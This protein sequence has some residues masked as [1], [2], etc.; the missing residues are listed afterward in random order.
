MM[1]LSWIVAL[2]LSVLMAVMGCAA[3]TLP[4]APMPHLDTMPVR[5]TE[6]EITVGA[7]PYVQP[8]R[9]LDAFDTRLTRK[10][11]LPIQLFIKNHR[12]QNL[13]V[14]P[15]AIKLELPDGSQ[16]DVSTTMSMVSQLSGSEPEKYKPVVGPTLM[17]EGLRAGDPMGGAGLLLLS[18]PITMLEFAVTG[19]QGLQRKAW[20]ARLA[21]YENVSL[22]EATLEKGEATYGFVFFA[23]SPELQH[24]PEKAMLHLAFEVEDETKLSFDLPLNGLGFEW[25]PTTEAPSMPQDDTD[26]VD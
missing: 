17:V 8:A 7:D 6:R 20:Q 1:R 24:F 10:G 21:T 3:R 14:R 4:P 9:Q 25:E 13:A 5:H 23:L 19:A 26:D 15:M 16:L 11:I 12:G 18:I 2:C 22:R